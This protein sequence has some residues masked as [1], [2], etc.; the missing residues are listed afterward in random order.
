MNTIAT[1]DDGLTIRELRHIIGQFEET[2][3]DGNEARIYIAVGNLHLSI[4]VNIMM[5]DDGDMV[6]VPE[7]AQ[8]IMD[9][10][11]TWDEFTSAHA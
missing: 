4:A 11:N 5:D 1:N 8:E 10:L 6:L 3:V 2:D 7:H 9:Q